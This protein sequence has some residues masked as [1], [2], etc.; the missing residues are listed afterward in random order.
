MKAEM[1]N[2]HTHTHSKNC[3]PLAD[4][5][6]VTNLTVPPDGAYLY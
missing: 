2:K 4:E 3:V 6:L 1:L 5:R